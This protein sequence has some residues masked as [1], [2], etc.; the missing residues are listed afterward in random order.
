MACNGSIF[1][2]VSKKKRVLSLSH[3]GLPFMV[4]E[5]EEQ[6]LDVLS[7]FFFNDMKNKDD[8]YS[9]EKLR[10]KTRQVYDNILGYKPVVSVH[11]L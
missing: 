8:E 9:A 6:F 7:E 5:Y 4:D 11:I 1:V 2:S 10:I 3:K